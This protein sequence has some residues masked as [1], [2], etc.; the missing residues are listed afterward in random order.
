MFLL[1]FA[2]RDD[3]ESR[4]ALYTVH[5]VQGRQLCHFNKITH[6]TFAV[7]CV[8]VVFCFF[9]LLLLLY[10]TTY[11]YRWDITGDV[12]INL[13]KLVHMGG[14]DAEGR[15]IRHRYASSFLSS[16]FFLF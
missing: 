5:S 4:D 16:V 9:W 7:C 10:I 11:A 13:A 15:L 8:C 1:F 14:R 6:A 3:D 12:I 2:E